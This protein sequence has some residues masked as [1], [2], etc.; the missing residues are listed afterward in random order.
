M[1]LVWAVAVLLALCATPSAALAMPTDGVVSGQLV[2]MTSGGGSTAGVNVVLVA[3]GRKEQAPLG[4]Q[5]VATDADGRFAFDGLDRDPN[6][7]YLVVSRY[8]GVNYPGDAPFQ[9]QDEATHR[10]DVTVYDST[11]VDDGL[12]IERLNLLVLGADQGSVQFM[13]MGALVN[14]SDRTFVSANPQDQQ[15]ARAVRF[16]LPPGALGVQM[17]SGFTQQDVIPGVGGIQVVTPLLPGRHEFALSFQLPYNGSSADLSLQMP[18][19][20]AAFNV[21]L[22]NTGLRLDASSLTAGEPATLG[23]QSYALYSAANLPRATLV[24]SRL[25]GLGSTPGGLGPTQLAL[26]SLGVVLFVLGGGVLLFG[27]RARAPRVMMPIPERDLEQERLEL[28]VRLAV[29]DERYAAGQ[30]KQSD[31]EHERSRG[32]QRLRELLLTLRQE[33][34][35][36]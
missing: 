30:V 34:A 20:T 31:Y 7:V 22:P 21:Y 29:L 13:Q 15:L 8:G 11:S 2:N 12:Q 6:V 14:N 35:S 28:V 26:I 17:E 19:P 24:P 27:A 1:K 9:L 36:P 3:F 18:Y 23:G 16:P 32:K 25:N 4:Q 10:T 5:T 33:S